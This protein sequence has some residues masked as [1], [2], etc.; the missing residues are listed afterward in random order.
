L[1]VSVESNHIEVQTRQYTDGYTGSLHRAGGTQLVIAVLEGEALV[2][3]SDG[4]WERWLR[5]GDV[6]ISEGEEDE[7][8]RLSLPGGNARVEAV[9]FAPRIAHALRWVP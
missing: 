6:F 8:L 9:T 5:P 1:N 7:D 3:A 4:P 2:T